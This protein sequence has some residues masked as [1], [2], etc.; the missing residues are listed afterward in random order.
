[1][2]FR[3]IIAAGAIAAGFAAPPPP[4]AGGPARPAV[5]NLHAEFARLAGHVTR[6][7]IAGVVPALGTRAS[8]K[9]AAGCTE[10][11]CPLAYHGGSV[12]HAPRVY[13]VLWGNWSSQAASTAESFLVGLYQGLGAAPHNT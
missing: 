12:Q 10:P 5:V 6:G 13:L 7:P 11:G 9:A 1:M 2:Y 8:A 4:A 3:G